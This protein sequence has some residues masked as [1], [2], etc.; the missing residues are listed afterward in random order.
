MVQIQ[1]VNDLITVKKYPMI[2]HDEVHLEIESTE[3]G[4]LINYPNFHL[5]HKNKHQNINKGT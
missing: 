2:F 4:N 1:K 5:I 3:Q